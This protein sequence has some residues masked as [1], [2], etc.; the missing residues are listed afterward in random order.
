MTITYTRALI[1]DDLASSRE[2]LSQAL[3]LAFPAIE[4]DTAASLTEA[5]QHLE[6]PPPIAL[7]DLGLPDGSGVQLDRKSVV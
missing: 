1:V 4:I 2:W 5:A 6:P 3:Q 7:I